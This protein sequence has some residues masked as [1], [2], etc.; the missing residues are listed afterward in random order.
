[1][2]S[3]TSFD[4]LICL[5]APEHAGDACGILVGNVPIAKPLAIANLGGFLEHVCEGFIPALQ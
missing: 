2:T 5:V 4:M 1:M 3:F